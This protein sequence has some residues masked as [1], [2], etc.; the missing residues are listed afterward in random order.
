MI[1]VIVATRV[2]TKELKKAQSLEPMA[3][4]DQLRDLGGWKAMVTL[5][6]DNLRYAWNDY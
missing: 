2:E 4:E 6:L 5:T 3:E 1:P